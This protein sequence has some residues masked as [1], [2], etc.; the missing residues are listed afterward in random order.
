MGGYWNGTKP[1]RFVH[2]KGP[3]PGKKNKYL[4]RDTKKGGKNMFSSLII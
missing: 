2:N 1:A 4:F 3:H